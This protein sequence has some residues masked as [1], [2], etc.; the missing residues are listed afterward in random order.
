MGPLE[1]APLPLDFVAVRGASEVAHFAGGRAQDSPRAGARLVLHAGLEGDTLR[2]WQA[3]GALCIP[4]VRLLAL[5]APDEA[6]REF[7]S[8]RDLGERYVRAAGRLRPHGEVLRAA[9]GLLP[10]SDAALRSLLHRTLADIAVASLT[11][12]STVQR[13]AVNRPPALP[14]STADAPARFEWP[15]VEPHALLDQAFAHLHAWQRTH[16]ALPFEP[17]AGQIDMAHAVLDAL[18]DG[19]RLVVEAGT[20]VGKTIAYALPMLLLAATRGGRYLVSTHTRNLQHQLV[21]RDL[22]ELWRCFGLDTVPH[23][24]GE[25]QGLVFAKLLGRTNYV[26]RT[27]LARAARRATDGA[28]SFELAQV[29]LWSLGT[30]SGELD[31]IASL[32]DPALLRELQSRR[33]SCGGRACR[34]EPPCPVYAAREAARCADLVVV[35]HALLFSDAGA[36]GGLLGRFAGLVIDEAHHLESVATEHL[37]VRIGRQ[38]AD[39]FL[40]PL[41]RLVAAARG[42][43]DAP[44]LGA[45]I[46]RH[47]A[48]VAA[49]RGRLHELLDALEASLPRPKAR[50]PR[51]A[52]HDG[53]EVFGPVR[54]QLDALQ[55]ALAHGARSALELQEECREKMND[56]PAEECAAVLDLLG[57]IARETAAALEFLA[58]GNNE[59]WAFLLDFGAAGTKLGE[60]AALPL[61][62]APEVQRLLSDVAPAAV[63]TS[64]TLAVGGEFDYFLGRVGL[65]GGTPSLVVPSPFD[66][67]SQCLVVRAQHLCEYTD[68]EFE[69]QAADILASVARRTGRRMLVLLT[70][71]AGLR[72]LHAELGQRLAG[73]VTLLAQDVSGSRARVAERFVATPGAVLLGTASFWEG[74]DFPGE[75]LEV[76]SIVKLPF[77]VPDDP[78]VAARCDRLRRL[79]GEPFHEYVLPEAV[80]R[81]AQ[82]FGRLVRSRHDRGA[83][84]L[85]DTRLGDRSYRKAFLAALP[86]EPEVFHDTPALVER[87]GGWLEADGAR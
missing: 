13:G 1:S 10:Q 44:G 53:D 20:G 5:L 74:V 48:D 9:A 45:R 43:A 38:H 70:S 27:A 73:S 40:P 37:S 35:N 60:I 75:A 6:R 26:C 32:L 68:V 29:L 19:G 46:E 21:D 87:V 4:A 12:A 84:L 82:G 36:E 57:G 24:D 66:Y 54:E 23:P 85:L 31:E 79:G 78:L 50:R 86:V 56:A 64:A 30:P 16:T 59:D 58:T 28:G 25:R 8:A 17:R 18:L 15:E 55:E 61:D 71:H 42:L 52:Y 49:L 34:G 63:Y 65:A 72:R 67:A 83:V 39:A 77:L 14:K 22:P 47:G 76:L 80:L 41:G 33:E 62:V 7:A 69:P 51:Q 2:S 81:F 11:E 3:T